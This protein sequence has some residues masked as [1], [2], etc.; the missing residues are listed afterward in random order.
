MSAQK[1]M[2]MGRL[3]VGTLEN[4]ARRWLLRLAGLWVISASLF[5]GLAH[6]QSLADLA[7]LSSL[8]YNAQPLQA[9]TIPVGWRVL[10]EKQ[11]AGS[12]FRG[13]AFMHDNASVV[14]G[15]A[16]TEDSRDV[17]ADLG[18]GAQEF[19]KVS[20]EMASAFI[21]SCAPGQESRGLLCYPV[22]KVGYTSDGATLC[23]LN[24][25]HD[26]KATPG[27]CQYKF[28]SI[29]LCT[30]ALKG[31]KPSCINDNK[32]SRGI[33]NA[34][35][36]RT[37]EPTRNRLF[38][39]TEKTQR[40]IAN[41][42][43]FYQ[44]ALASPLLRA[45]APKVVIITGHSL[46]AFLAQVIG[47]RHATTVTHTF[48]GPGAAEFGSHTANMITNYIR[49]DDVAGSFGTH[50]G[51]LVRFP[52]IAGIAVDYLVQ[53]HG[54]TPFYLDLKAGMKPLQ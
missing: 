21:K 26:T 13:V 5:V 12:G 16:G 27:F 29:G 30:G 32:Y 22:C 11:D 17:L 10:L 24:C 48:N 7:M 23:Y 54:I 52:N 20:A 4:S 49:K 40:Q 25:P 33:G 37:A 46:G 51:T 45:Q 8:T 31:L 3:S 2:K 15:Y 36:V 43:S 14:I 28:G 1:P 38:P 44:A 47:S 39:G 34:P 50:L 18:I 42:E 19:A 35:S 9:S 6:A 53:N 41:A